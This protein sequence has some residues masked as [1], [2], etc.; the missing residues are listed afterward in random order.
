MQEY[1][2]F[3]L[4]TLEGNIVPGR[5]IRKPRGRRSRNTSHC[6]L[7]T[8][9]GELFRRTFI[10]GGGVYYYRTFYGKDQQQ[11]SEET[12]GTGYRAGRNEKTIFSGLKEE[13]G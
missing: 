12:K 10:S 4:L 8:A 3:E 13:K 1:G 2:P 11:Q 9:F 7:G 6:T 5:G